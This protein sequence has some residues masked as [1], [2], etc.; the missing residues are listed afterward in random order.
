MVIA[1]ETDLPPDKAAWRREMKRRWRE[2]CV[3]DRTATTAALVEAL[4]LWLTSRP[5]TALWFSP[6]PDEPDLR[7]LAWECFEMGRRLALPRVTG[8]GL[9]IHEWDGQ[10]ASL[11][12]GAMGI[13]EPEPTLCPEIP[14]STLAV[15]VIP[16]LAFDPQTGIRL[17]RGAGYY[18]RW[19]ANSGFAGS[20]VGLALPWQ[21]TGPLPREAHDRPMDWLATTSGVLRPGSF[22]QTPGTMASYLS[23]P[24]CPGSSPENSPSTSP[25][26]RE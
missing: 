12:P 11:A 25:P 6:L 3:E 24:C 17:G 7:A 4:R 23:S 20:S 15:A 5:G 2:S 14:A 9:V 18:D 10:T 26:W 16:G 21:L 8:D 13:L 1:M 19:L 22:C